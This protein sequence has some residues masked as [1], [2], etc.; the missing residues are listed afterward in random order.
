MN[1]AAIFLVIVPHRR[2]WACIASN[3]TVTN[4]EGSG[5]KQTAAVIMVAVAAAEV[6]VVVVVVVL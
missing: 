4:K 6:V 1:L 3:G 5:R 2:S